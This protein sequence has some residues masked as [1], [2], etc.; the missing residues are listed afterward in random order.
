MEPYDIDRFRDPSEI[1][2]SVLLKN[3][4]GMQKQEIDDLWFCLEAKLMDSSGQEFS[5]LWR[6]S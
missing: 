2:Y 1:L 4:L 3:E 5:Y 6:I